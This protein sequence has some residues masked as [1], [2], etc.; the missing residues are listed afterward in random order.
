MHVYLSSAIR[1][2]GTY[3]NLKRG[4]AINDVA[5][6]CGIRGTDLFGGVTVAMECLDR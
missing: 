5:F 4:L 6:W 1:D 3:K 2:I